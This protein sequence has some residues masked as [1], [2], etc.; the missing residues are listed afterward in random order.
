[1]LT[2]G[3]NV[4]VAKRVTVQGKEVGISFDGGDSV[5][6]SVS[7]HEGLFAIDETWSFAQDGNYR[8]HT[9]CNLEG[10]EPS[11]E[12]FI[13]AVWYQGNAMGEG[14]FPSIRKS[15]TW[16]FL[17]TRMSIPCA[18]QMM[19][20][21]RSL[22]LATNPAKEEK[23]LCSV[24]WDS[25]SAI[26]SI[27]GFESPL[28][29]RGKAALV[30]MGEQEKPFFTLK[31][32][33]TY[34]RTFYLSI[35]K[36]REPLESWEHFL[37]LLEPMLP[38]QQEPLLSWKTYGT[39]KLVRLLSL[40]KKGKEGGAYLAMGEDNGEE[41]A[42]YGYTAASFLVKGVE[43]AYAFARTGADGMENDPDLKKA[44]QRI[45]DLFHLND[46]ERLLTDLS[47][48]L[49]DYYLKAERKKGVF[50]DCHD[51]ERDI[52]GGYLGIGEHPE[53]KMMV[54]SRCNGEA[55]LSYLR[56]YK[57][58]AKQGI[59]KK[60][61]LNLAKRVACFYRDC[62]LSDG[63]F[64]RWWTEGG[65]PA[66]TQGTNGAY[67]AVFFCALLSILQKDDPLYED[68]RSSLLH[69]C[70][71]YGNL[72]DEGLY[73]GDTLDADSCDKEAG[74]VLLSLF[75]DTY[76]AT[77]DKRYLALARKA[78]SFVLTW[79]WQEDGW[80][81]SDSPMA[82]H[83]FHTQGMT[84]VSVAH[85]HLD[86]YGMY[87]A[88]DFQRLEE[89]TGDAYYGRQARL[90]MN[91]CR[92]LVATRSD[93]LGKKERYIGWQPEQMNH[94]DWDYFNREEMMRGHFDIDIAWVN[95]LGYDSYLSLKEKGGL[96]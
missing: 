15:R 9:A 24:T 92:Q 34:S 96:S 42:V 62:Q 61:Y 76:G 74:V 21:T 10:Q 17:E 47:I 26:F 28:S 83:H 40:V 49:G 53:F 27:P 95:V 50:Q 80:L 45:A 58:L 70:S 22:N 60:E 65:K 85:H 39:M 38:K 64:G 56:L 32:H 59:E 81:P 3:A 78:A 71:F 44:R 77:G 35:E 94:T 66:N 25:H 30:S 51:I 46:D 4:L 67:I 54:N 6:L 79:I 73:Y 11:N 82:K 23:E 69:A 91:A 52:W 20:G 90:M 12:I 1:M 72:V 48:L 63:S 13:P 37:R 19:N 31:A 57:E 43:A 16:S 2:Y 18:I 7:E 8:L 33:D 55:M 36:N 88:V 29:Y 14:A 41:Q 93:L 68:I 84:S 75:L 87:I 86:F 5:F 89:A